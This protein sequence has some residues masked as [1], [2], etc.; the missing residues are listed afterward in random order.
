MS[1][2]VFVIGP[3]PFNRERLERIAEQAGVTVHPL[4]RY[5]DVRGERYPLDDLL[6]RA[7]A[8][9]RAADSP[10]D[11][12]AGFWD[13]PVSDMVPILCR[14]LG[15]RGPSLEAVV[16]C[17]DKY[18]SRLEQRKV[19]PDC[20]PRFARF[21]PFADDPRAQIELD[22]PFWIKPI[23][24]WRS[25]LGFHIRD[26]AGLREAVTVIRAHIERLSEP[27]NELLAH[28]DLPLGIPGGEGGFCIAEEII[29]GHQCTL[30]GY[31][32]DGEVTIYGIVDSIRY[33]NETTFSRYQYPSHLPQGVQA[34]LI[35]K[36]EAV[37]AFLGLDNTTFNIEFFYDDKRDRTWLLEINPRISQ[38]HSDLFEKVDGYSNLRILMDV[39]RGRIPQR[40]PGAGE[41]ACAAK[42]FLRR[43]EDARVAAVPGP[44]DIARLRQAVPGAE[45]E[46]EVAPGMRLSDLADQDSYSYE[47]GFVFVGADDQR[48]LLERIRLCEE[49]LTFDLRPTEE[50]D[51]G[52]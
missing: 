45:V 37:V 8:Q 2:Q 43:F 25:Q 3:D 32:L 5:E 49:L 17:E 29:G 18:W 11:A 24:A 4:L 9:L 34:R 12:L 44:E 41:A 36:A 19:I 38:S 30:E 28:L 13:F 35:A 48:Q 46:I 20:V 33:A 23:K 10:P 15:L 39:A 31:S 40:R 22:F 51:H 42:Y 27:F 50:G 6:A 47:L 52:R 16:R 14:R 21:D 7:E 1:D 26:E